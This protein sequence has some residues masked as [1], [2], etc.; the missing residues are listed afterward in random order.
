MLR[1]LFSLRTLPDKNMAKIVETI[2]K[3]NISALL[4]IGGFEVAYRSCICRLLIPGVRV[5]SEWFSVHN[6]GD[7]D[8]KGVRRCAAAV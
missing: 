1:F 3:L 2:T 6:V 8:F 5:A 4:V 7:L